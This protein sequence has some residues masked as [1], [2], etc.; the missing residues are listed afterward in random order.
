[1]AG[2]A[3]VGAYLGYK[4]V[5]SEDEI[6]YLINSQQVRPSH[7]LGKRS[8]A[9]FTLITASSASYYIYQYNRG[10]CTLFEGLA[11]TVS[12]LGYGLFSH[13]GS[14]LYHFNSFENRVFI[15]WLQSQLRNSNDTIKQLQHRY[16]CLLAQQHPSE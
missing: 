14:Y 8:I 5:P 7:S 6:L 9:F 13:L 12:I 4:R 3:L 15:P 16:N 2:S 11:V 10:N 1:M